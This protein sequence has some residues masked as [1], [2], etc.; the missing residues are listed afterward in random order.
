[1][2]SRRILFSWIGHTDMRAMAASLPAD[3]QAEV[4]KGLSPPTPLAGQ[5]GPIRCLLDE[6][7]FDEV[8]L[9]SDYPA[10]KA[11]AFV[12]W[13]GG[14][15]IL[16]PV[17]L[18][19]PTDY[20]E[21]F[22]VVD[23]ELAAVVSVPRADRLDLCIHLSPGTPA[24]TAIWLLLGK[25][26]YQPASFY[27]THERRAWLTDVPFDLVVDY[28]PQVLRDADARLQALSGESPQDVRG[29]ESIVGDG[30]SLR[31]AVGRAR[32]AA[33][34]D[35]SVLL[36]GES[37]T[38]KEL[39][40]RAIHDASRRR[41]R[42]FVAIN[43]AA[44]SRELLESELFGHVKGAFTGAAGDRDGAFQEADGGTLFL[45]EVG[46]CDPAMQAKLLRVLQP[47]E[48]DPC[49]RVF[50]RVGDS[51]P[52]TSNVRIIAATNRDLLAAVAERRFRSDLYY[53]LAVITIKLPPLR[54]RRQDIPAI[55]AALMGRINAAFARQEPG[56]VHKK[57]SITAIEFVRKHP[58][59]GNVRQLFNTLTQAAVMTDGEVLERADLADAVAEVPGKDAV[60]LLEL[61]LGNGFSLEDHLERIQKHYLRR[62]MEEA[63]GV[64]KRA[65]DL[66]G[67]RNYQTLAAQLERLDVDP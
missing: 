31:V 18:A 65:A 48:N 56:Y 37:G 38:G 5:P 53:R 6:E 36:L 63:G 25:S 15:P 4:L 32:R 58:W 50:Y 10:S 28:V 34:R 26:R 45:D 52:R 33:P 17:K 9:L 16:H 61:P 67:Y 3:R 66:L 41:A 14:S 62:A 30:R 46:E 29:F 27:Q 60:D 23:A 49:H 59:P 21:I 20:A 47:P 39:F 7:H 57:I 8:H 64:K 55:A 12:K 19:N 22:R 42:P 13:L 11:Q 54:E 35:V 2:K 43:C 44:I 51:K 1:M 24:M 40:A